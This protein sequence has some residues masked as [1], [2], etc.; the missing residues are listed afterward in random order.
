MKPTLPVFIYEP[1]DMNVYETVE[2]A[3]LSLEAIDV[4]D[5]VYTGYD[6]DGRLLKLIAE[7]DRI[8]IRLAEDKANHKQDLEIA[9]VSF[10][11][12]LM[13]PFADESNVSFKELVQYCRKFASAK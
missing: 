5:N 3:E 2:S 1:V 7:Q 9:I 11:D 13:D 6:A 10:L 8:K 4:N 12:A